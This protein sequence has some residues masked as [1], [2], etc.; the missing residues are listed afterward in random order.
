[1]YF[2]L[3]SA[4][5]LGVCDFLSLTLSVC[6]SIRL[7]VCHGQT[8]NRF[9]FFVSRRNRAIFWPSVLHV[10]LYKML[11]LDF[12]FRPPNTQNL[13]PKIACDNATLPRRHTWSCTRQ[14]SS[15]LEKVGNRLNFVADH[16]CHGNEIW[17]SRGDLNAY[18]L[19]A[20][21]IIVNYHFHWEILQ[22][23]TFVGWL[24]HSL[25]FFGPNISNTVGDRGSPQVGNGMSRIKCENL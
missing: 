25:T 24:V 18:W 11:F 2:L 1:M 21:F 12:W 13:L 4:P 10:A 23:I 14:F 8:S 7:S 6:L 17:P 22:S 9:F 16:C 20:V 5:R 3:I 15:C 19:V